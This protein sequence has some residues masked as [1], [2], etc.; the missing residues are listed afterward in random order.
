M[1]KLKQLQE[2]KHNTKLRLPVSPEMRSIKKG[3]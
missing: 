2:R 3:G 1:T